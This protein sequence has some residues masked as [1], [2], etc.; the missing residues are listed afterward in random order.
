MLDGMTITNP[1]TTANVPA[2]PEPAH[3]LHHPDAAT[4][5]RAM[6]RRSIATLATVSERGRPHAATVLYQLVDDVLYTSTSRGSRKAR[7]V[8]E[9]GVA[10]VTIAVRRLP[11]GPPSSIQ[12]QASAAVLANDDPEVVGF[13]AAGRLDKITSHG[14]LDLEGGCFLRIALPARLHTYAL[15]MSLWQVLRN[16]LAVA[17]EVEL[18]TD[19]GPG[20]PAGSSVAR[21]RQ[22]GRT[23]AGRG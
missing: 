12:F 11:V 1:P 19:A 14:E 5:R 22:L 8:A 3:R 17:G 21:I 4:I 13:A 9:T 6:E 7:N 23:P 20:Q 18:H 10:A 2:T 15:G 16:P